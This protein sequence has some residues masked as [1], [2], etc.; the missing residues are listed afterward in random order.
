M[1]QWVKILFML[2]LGHIDAYAEAPANRELK[3][4]LSGYEWQLVRENWLNMRPSPADDLIDLVRDSNDPPY[5]KARAIAVLSLFPENKVWDFF[6]GLLSNERV[7][8]QR[9]IVDALCSTFIQEKP[10]E[11]ESHMEI[12][13]GAADAHLRVRAG[14]CLINIGSVSANLAVAQYRNRLQKDSWEFKALDQ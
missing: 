14:R 8:T 13:L 4:L 6:V 2:W 10:I 1:K 12:F 7:V 9:R 11:L 5:I 3:H